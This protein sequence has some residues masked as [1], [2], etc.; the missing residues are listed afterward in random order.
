MNQADR[1]DD[2]YRKLYQDDFILKKGFERYRF[3]AQ[4]FYACAATLVSKAGREITASFNIHDEAPDEVELVVQLLNKSSLEQVKT[5]AGIIA[6]KIQR[7]VMVYDEP[8]CISMVSYYDIDEV[9][10][11]T[12]AFKISLEEVNKVVMFIIK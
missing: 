12:E 2:F 5:V 9:K 6:K 8:E 3:G 11:V 1:I 10:E 7:D 4:E